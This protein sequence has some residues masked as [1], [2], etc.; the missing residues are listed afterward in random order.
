MNNCVQGEDYLD[1]GGASWA[2]ITATCC[3]FKRDQLTEVLVGNAEMANQH[4]PPTPLHFP[5]GVV[6]IP[7]ES[8][9]LKINHSKTM[10]RNSD[11][12]HP[13]FSNWIVPSLIGNTAKN[14]L[15]VPFTTSLV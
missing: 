6:E 14:N 9:E 13:W 15:M 1:Q 10:T 11:L 2:W 3:T 8:W 4:E 5:D 7:L 12:K